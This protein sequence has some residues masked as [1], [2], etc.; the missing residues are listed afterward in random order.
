MFYKTSSVV[1][2]FKQIPKCFPLV[3]FKSTRKEFYEECC[4]LI[5]YVSFYSVDSE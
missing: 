3:H 1:I 4:N 5:G 2:S